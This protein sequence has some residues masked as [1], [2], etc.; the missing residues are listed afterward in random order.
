MLDCL[1]KIDKVKTG[2]SGRM[3]QYLLSG[4]RRIFFR[5]FI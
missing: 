1:K 2:V 4:K 5:E 3:Q